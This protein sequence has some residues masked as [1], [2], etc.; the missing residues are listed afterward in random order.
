M[1]AGVRGSAISHLCLVSRACHTQPISDE[2]RL[3]ENYKSE[4]FVFSIVVTSTATSMKYITLPNKSPCLPTPALIT[5]ACLC[6]IISLGSRHRCHGIQSFFTRI[7]LRAHAA[8]FSEVQGLFKSFSGNRQLCLVDSIS[9]SHT[10]RCSR[11]H[12]VKVHTRPR[13]GSQSLRC[14]QASTWDKC[15]QSVPQPGTYAA[16]NVLT[17]GIWPSHLTAV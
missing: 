10:E 15:L 8:S 12:E 4:V 17:A 16:D 5:H 9:E 13:V 3:I 7:F 2:W 1:R 11:L 14:V 6:R